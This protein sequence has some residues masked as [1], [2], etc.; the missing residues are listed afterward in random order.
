MDIADDSLLVYTVSR[1]ISTLE[2]LSS[3]TAT[4]VNICIHRAQLPPKLVLELTSQLLLQ[5][6]RGMEAT[7]GGL[8]LAISQDKE[9]S[10]AVRNSV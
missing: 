5:A 3:R 1:A 4:D 2:L 8:L 9:V 6:S 10:N 7:Q